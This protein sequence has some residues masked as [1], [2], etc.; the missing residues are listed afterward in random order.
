MNSTGSSF[1]QLSGLY[2]PSGIIQLPD[3]RF[4][5][6]EDEKDHP[7]ALVSIGAGGSVSSRALT[8]G[9]FD[10]NEAFW[11]LDDL[12]GLTIDRSGWIYA[13]TSQSLDG[14][15]KRKKSREK[16]VRFR[17]EDERVF[18]A[19]SV[20]TLKAALT[21]A[22]PLLAAAAGVK[23]VKSHGGFNIEALEITPDGQRL[24][25]GFRSP[26]FEGRAILASVENPA[27][28]FE[29]DAALR[30][31]ATLETLDLDGDGVRGMTY[32]HALSGYLL[33]SGPVS[34][35]PK[36]FRLWFWNG[37]PGAPAQLVSISGVLGIEHAEGICPAVIDGVERVIMVSDD[38]SRAEKRCARFLMLDPSQLRIM[39]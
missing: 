9:W 21:E 14:D 19:Q 23:D 2:E 4:L 25:L 30:V 28:I 16:L 12:E 10:F 8:A 33:I 37:A 36:P 15:G 6:V 34:R 29:S 3:G 27:E 22:H 38:G 26:L 5:A 31:G 7:F 32:A 18:A 13:L 35:E 17:I 24:W 1:R 11:K 39:L 20:T